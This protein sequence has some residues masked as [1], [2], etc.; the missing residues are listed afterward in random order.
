MNSISALMMR[1]MRRLL[2]RMRA[3]SFASVSLEM[4]AARE[5]ACGHEHRVER[6][7]QI[8]TDDADEPL[9][10][11]G[12]LAQVLLRGVGAQDLEH[13]LLVRLA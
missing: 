7:A 9:A 5:Q 2:S 11:L 1:F 8:V 6:A 10:K 12:D 4:P 13:E 3:A